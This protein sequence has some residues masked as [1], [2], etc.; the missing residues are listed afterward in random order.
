MDS[1][2][3]EDEVIELEVLTAGN[4]MSMMQSDLS[5]INVNVNKMMEWKKAESQHSLRYTG[6]SL[7]TRQRHVKAPQEKVR[8]AVK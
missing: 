8:Q 2:W 7:C 4:I 3:S 1:E 5:I 6:T